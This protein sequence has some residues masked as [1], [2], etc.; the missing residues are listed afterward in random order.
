MPDVR[1]K[2]R[3]V[4]VSQYYL[5][6]SALVSSTIARALKDAGHSVRVI[7]SYP[8]Y[9]EG[10]IYPGYKQRWRQRE[11]IDGVDV[12]RV[13]MFIDHSTKAAKR[14]L[15]YASFAASSAT[16][17]RFARGADVIYIYATQMTPALGPWLWRLT[18]GAP[19][20]LHVQDLWPDSVTGSSIVSTSPA[21]RVITGV[22]NPWLR[23]VY[24]RASAVIGIAPRMTSSLIERGVP[25]ERVHL[26][27]NWARPVRQALRVRLSGEAP[28]VLF[29][30]NIGDMQDL[31][32]VVCAAHRVM[33]T[34]LRFHIVGGGVALSRVKELA[35]RIGA[36]NVE[37]FDRV[38]P[39]RMAEIYAAADYSLVTL[40]DL[41]VFSGTI[42]SK[43]QASLAYGLPV[44][45][46]VSGDVRELTEQNEVGFTANP[47]DVDSLESALRKAANQSARERLEMRQR[48][49][50]FYTR[51]FSAESALAA[52]EGILIEATNQ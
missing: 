10:K 52:I 39:D 43:F 50:E 27:F 22:L 28:I 24:G 7:T 51:R 35:R 30:G 40:K 44:I 3:V 29:A 12:L 8:N 37:F 6:E 15:N 23:S 47:E 21:T 20:V 17:R 18:G 26:V 41:P 31:E 2:L 16:A 14:M 9:P 48:A 49:A 38:L 13:P 36:S 19:Y 4:I 33:D 25:S 42:P 34:P 11:M 46:T 45:S 32:T 1:E 5:P